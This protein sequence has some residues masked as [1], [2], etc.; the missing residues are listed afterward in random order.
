MEEIKNS[1]PQGE[2]KDETL[3]GVSGGRGEGDSRYGG[4]IRGSVV[5]SY[6]R[7]Y[8][9][10]VECKNMAD[11]EAEEKRIKE[12]K[13]KCSKCMKGYYVLKRGSY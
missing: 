4:P 6:C 11:W 13:S 8:L 7:Y 12:N 3:N 1:I 10:T 2:L 5:C 9:G